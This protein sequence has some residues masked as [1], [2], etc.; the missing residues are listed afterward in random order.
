M[1]HLRRALA[2]VKIARI[3]QLDDHFVGNSTWRCETFALCMAQLRMT[4]QINSTSM[5]P[6]GGW[7]ALTL[8]LA[9]GVARAD[10]TTIEPEADTTLFQGFENSNGAGIF[11]FAGN[12]NRF[13]ERRALLRFDI[14][15]SVPV[16][17]TITRVR[18]QLTMDQSI[19]STYSFSL[20][21]ITAA[22]NEGTVNAGFPG[23]G[24]DQAQNGDATWDAR[25]YNLN[26]QLA[27]MWSS[28]GGDYAATP[29]AT[30]S[31]GGV[32]LYT[33]G[34]NAAIV[35]NVQGWL[36]QPATNF[37]W[38]LVGQNFV[39][40]TAKRFVSREN[41]DEAARPSL[42]IEFTPPGPTCN[43]IDINNDNSFFDPQDIEALLSIFS[44]GPCVPTMSTCDGIDFNND[45]SLF[46][47][48]DISSFLLAF[49]EGPCT[50]CGN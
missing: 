21:R 29:S 24:G 12:T 11:L 40:A 39:G 45:G 25:V 1:N 15:G 50:S 37:G 2:S 48:C 32:G 44:E 26:P 4:H 13:G 8:A 10:T 5:A 18:V 22:W 33:W 30:I 41:A 19:V 14:A 46:D 23:G 38:I 47:P 27:A 20:H 3:E 6:L 28:P 49:A 43:D 9:A 17:S 42:E 35:A 16:G 7:L 36:D 31:V 34:S